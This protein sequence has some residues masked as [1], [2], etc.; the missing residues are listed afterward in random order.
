M[1]CASSNPPLLCTCGWAHMQWGWD[2]MSLTILLYPQCNMTMKAY[3]ILNLTCDI[4]PQPS[5]SDIFPILCD[6]SCWWV[7]LLICWSSPRLWSA[8]LRMRST[9]LRRSYLMMDNPGSSGSRIW[10]GW[11]SNSTLLCTLFAKPSK[12]FPAIISIT[13]RQVLSIM[14][15]SLCAYTFEWLKRI[16]M[17]AGYV[18]DAGPFMKNC[19]LSGPHGVAV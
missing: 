10:T 6:F 17:Y 9:R 14:Y 12:Q 3:C 2:G 18:D 1:S 15:A 5:T 16:Q 11:R 13:T 8:V 7:I 19:S 4:S